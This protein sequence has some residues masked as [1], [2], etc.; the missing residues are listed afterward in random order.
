[1]PADEALLRRAKDGVT[2]LNAK[3]TQPELPTPFYLFHRPRLLNKSEG[4]WMG[5]ERKRGKLEQF[6]EALRGNSEHFCT[7]VGDLAG[8]P[9][10]ARAEGRYHDW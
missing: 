8:K 4:A 10:H 7:I 2:A 3:Y 5:W 1:M 6:N 9:Q